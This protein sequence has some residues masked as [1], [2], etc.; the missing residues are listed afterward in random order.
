MCDILINT[1]LNKNRNSKFNLNHK[2]LNFKLYKEINLTL[3]LNEDTQKIVSFNDDINK[4]KQLGFLEFGDKV[5]HEFKK[6]FNYELDK[7]INPIHL[8]SMNDCTFECIFQEIVRKDYNY[9]LNINDQKISKVSM[10]I[11]NTISELAP[12]IF[13]KLYID[14]NYS[15]N[16]DTNT[17]T[18]LYVECEKCVIYLIKLSRYDNGNNNNDF[19]NNFDANNKCVKIVQMKNYKQDLILM[20]DNNIFFIDKINNKI[21]IICE[22]DNYNKSGINSICIKKYLDGIFLNIISNEIQCLNFKMLITN[23]VLLFYK[24]KIDDKYIF[25]MT[26]YVESNNLT[27]YSISGKITA[28]TFLL[29]QLESGNELID[30]YDSNDDK[31]MCRFNVETNQIKYIKILPIFFNSESELDNYCFNFAKLLEKY[32]TIDTIDLN[33]VCKINFKQYIDSSTIK[34]FFAKK[35]LT[36][37]NFESKHMKINMS[38]ANIDKIISIYCYNSL[39]DKYYFYSNENDFPILTFNMILSDLN[40]RIVDD[41]HFHDKKKNDPENILLSDTDYIYSPYKL[42]FSD[43]QKYNFKNNINSNS[44]SYLIGFMLELKKNK[45]TQSICDLKKVP[46]DKIC[47]YENNMNCGY[48]DNLLDPKRNYIEIIHDIILNKKPL[49]SKNLLDKLFGVLYTY[50]KINISQ[51]V[52]Q[53]FKNNEKYCM[54]KLKYFDITYET[55]DND[56]IYIAD[57]DVDEDDI[58]LEEDE[59]DEEDEN[60]ENDE[61]NEDN[62]EDEN[63]ENDEDNEEDEDD[64]EQYYVI[65]S[66]KS[67]YYNNN[68]MSNELYSDNIKMYG[69]TINLLNNNLVLKF[70][71]SCVKK[72]IYDDVFNEENYKFNKYEPQTLTQITT[73]N[74]II[75]KQYGKKNK[76]HVEFYF[77]NEIGDIITISSIYNVYKKHANT[78]ASK[79]N[80]QSICTFKYDNLL[81]IRFDINQTNEISIM[82]INLMELKNNILTQLMNKFNSKNTKLILNNKFIKKCANKN[83]FQLMKSN[84]AKLCFTIKP[85]FFKD[86]IEFEYNNSTKTCLTF[87]DKNRTMMIHYKNTYNKCT[88]EIYVCMFGLNDLFGWMYGST[89]STTQIPSDT[90]NYYSSNPINTT[91]STNA[92]SSNIK[93]NING[94]M[95]YDQSGSNV[96]VKTIPIGLI[97]NKPKYVWKVC[98]VKDSKCIVKLELENDSKYIIPVKIEH[99][100]Y[101]KNRCDKAKVVGIYKINE[102]ENEIEYDE[103]V[104]AIPFISSKYLEYKK[105]NIVCSDSFDLNVNN[106]CTNGIHVFETKQQAIN[107]SKNVDTDDDYINLKNLIER[108]KSESNEIKFDESMSSEP[109]PNKIDKPEELDEFQQFI[110]DELGII[111]NKKDGSNINIIDDMNICNDLNNKP[112][113]NKH[114][115][116]DENGFDENGFDVNGFDTNGFDVNGFDANG[117]DVNGFDANGYDMDGNH[118]DNLDEESY[119]IPKSKCG[120][121]K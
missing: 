18:I 91:D 68:N 99:L 26:N 81:N 100:M 119:L 41:K 28:N 106:T 71:K 37:I 39:L 79:N 24:Q 8:Y 93:I 112:N 51:F 109:K 19:N 56:S 80:Y 25:R 6:V 82:K 31:I 89:H 63:D 66:D 38:I 60:D 45:S 50:D 59:E 76:S 95:V 121:R 47:K 92:T 118:M 61:D 96:S 78:I 35:N 9:G 108:H 4:F 5:I 70:N 97:E 65:K 90:F 23:K 48:F 110:N 55:I 52:K 75:L 27:L 22:D 120:L 54:V 42:N 98:K 16:N 105:N 87:C 85:K 17:D 11:N 40:K 83:I 62:E 58:I 116:Y 117:Y 94:D 10:I 64:E 12:T 34:L 102:N 30:I 7:K 101:G 103:E 114:G 2:S 29:S 53:Q 46:F 104:I 107:F 72:I 74:K 69:V 15:T 1:S 21:K 73:G 3:N 36:K 86:K 57:G 113:K 43:E 44:N 77:K 32:E 111:N 33:D 20:E 115:V 88:S 84:Y 49:S 13:T 67:K 14:P